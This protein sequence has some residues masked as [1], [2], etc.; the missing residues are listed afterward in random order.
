VIDHSRNA[1]RNHQ[2]ERMH[3]VTIT[4]AVADQRSAIIDRN[5]RSPIAFKVN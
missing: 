4:I 1:E 5:R 2:Y 3:L